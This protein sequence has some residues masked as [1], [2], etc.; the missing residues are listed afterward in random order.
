MQELA[1]IADRFNQLASALDVANAENSRLCRDLITVQEEERRQIASELHDEVGPCLFGIMVNAGSIEQYADLLPREKADE[2][3]SRIGE[4]RKICDRLKFINRQL[5]KK[6]RP[7]VLGRITVKELIAKLT[8]EFEDR[9]PEVRFLTITNDL[10][11]TYGE[12]IDLTIY[13]C[14]QES[15]TNA[16]RHAEPSNIVVELTQER[17]TGPDG[18]LAS[19]QLRL[20]IRDDG[21]GISDP[22]PIGFG[23]G[24]MRERVKTLQGNFSLGRNWPAGTAINITIPTGTP[25]N[26]ETKSGELFGSQA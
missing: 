16:L 20:V 23:L 21:K 8:G 11:S 26:A 9:H 7:I 22:A 12:L 2:I 19:S 25:G 4:V 3:T 10:R 13:R 18:E 1:L 6:L 15:I 17:T 5:L 24:T 14:V